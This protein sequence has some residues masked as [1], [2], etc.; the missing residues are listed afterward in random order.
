MKKHS[1]IKSVGQALNLASGDDIMLPQVVEWV[2]QLGII[3]ATKPSWDPV[4]VSKDPNKGLV[5]AKLQK[6]R[7]C[8]LGLKI[9]MVY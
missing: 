7:G 4:V 1:C 5:Y 6:G 8:K 2:V 9:P 3:L